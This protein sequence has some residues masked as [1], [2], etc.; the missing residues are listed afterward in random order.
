[1]DVGGQLVAFIRRELVARFVFLILGQ[2]MLPGG[3]QEAGR[4]AGRV[5]NAFMLLRVDD[6]HDEIDDMTRGTEL[7]RVTLAAQHR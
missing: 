6:P 4:P 7:A 5:E 3:Y 2:D 1:M